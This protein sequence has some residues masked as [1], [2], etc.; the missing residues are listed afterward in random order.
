M[1]SKHKKGNTVCG[2]LHCHLKFASRCSKT[3]RKSE[4]EEEWFVGTAV[5]FHC[6][7]LCDNFFGTWLWAE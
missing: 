5:F 6:N 7:A 4:E 1:K 2:N 3:E